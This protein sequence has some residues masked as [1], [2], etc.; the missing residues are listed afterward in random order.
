M[1]L[2]GHL[3]DERNGLSWG[4]WFTVLGSGDA[5]PI[6]LEHISMPTQDGIG[7][8]DVQG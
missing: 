6:A 5:F 8:D 7:L 4:E 2:S 3:F 1:V